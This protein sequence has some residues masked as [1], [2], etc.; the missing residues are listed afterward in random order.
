MNARIQNKSNRNRK[1]FV[2][3]IEKGILR[4]IPKTPSLYLECILNI[5]DIQNVN[6]MKM[7]S[8]FS[9]GSAMYL[10]ALYLIE[11]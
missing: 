2:Y 8:L 5:P 10:K 3:Q 6:L 7:S 4:S 9:S 1:G 11:N